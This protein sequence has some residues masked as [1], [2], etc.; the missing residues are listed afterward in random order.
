M[1]VLSEVL[2]VV[3]LQGALFYYGEFSAPWCVKASSA[4]A[5]ARPFAPTAEHVIIFHLLTDDR[6]F[7]RRFEVPPARFRAKTRNARAAG[8]SVKNCSRLQ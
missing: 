4:R 7:K 5:L 3:K 2:K 8:R 1:D 6:A